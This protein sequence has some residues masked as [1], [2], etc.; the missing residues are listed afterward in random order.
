[1][2]DRDFCVDAAGKVIFVGASVVIPLIIPVVSDFDAGFKIVKII[3]LVGRPIEK[4]DFST[5]GGLPVV[6]TS[7]NDSEPFDSTLFRRFVGIVVS[8][9]VEK[10]KSSSD[11]GAAYFR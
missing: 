7:A 1:M 11:R 9:I 4:C 3:W 8:L 6:V 2:I 10:W 5:A